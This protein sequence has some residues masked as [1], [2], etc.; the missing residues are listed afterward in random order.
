MVLMNINF[1]FQ[2]GGLRVGQI[3]STIVTL[4]SALIIAFVFGW[5]LAIVLV[6]AVPFIAG[7]AYKQV[8]LVQK[9]QNRDSECMDKAG[10]VI[11]FLDFM[12]KKLFE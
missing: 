1:F 7:A 10:R 8:M 3:L 11:N 6:L 12:N 5:K 4:I 9:S 2:A